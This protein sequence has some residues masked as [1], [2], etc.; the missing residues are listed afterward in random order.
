MKKPPLF[1]QTAF[2]GKGRLIFVKFLL[3]I[4]VILLRLGGYFMLKPILLFWLSLVA[5]FMAMGQTRLAQKIPMI[6][7]HVYQYYHISEQAF[8]FADQPYRIFIAQPK[9]QAIERVLYVLDGNA[10]FPL[11]LN[12][13][14]PHKPLPLVIGLGYPANE[15]YPLSQRTRDYTFEACGEEFAQGGGA[16]VF[17]QFL[18]QR[19]LPFVSQHYVAKPQRT[20]LVGHSFGGLFALYT[21]FQ[22]GELFSDYVIASPSLWWGKGAIVTQRPT[23]LSPKVKRVLFTLSEYEQY[24]ARDPDISAE[25]LAR[26][27][28]RQQQHLPLGQLVQLL[29]QQYADTQIE[30]ALIAH[31]NHGSSI[32]EVIK[33]A[34]QQIQQP[35]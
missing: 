6:N 33:R 34:T 19:L 22:Q 28:A 1:C 5:S 21:L 2:G 14:D 32:P 15:A 31:K 30:L 23:Q 25:R 12:A 16:G 9:Q 13:L 20:L 24:P 27:T 7:P 10:Q 11:A 4:G 29:A 8:Q 26:I 18:Q 3:T 35:N 17:L